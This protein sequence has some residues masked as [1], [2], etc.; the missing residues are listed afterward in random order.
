[1]Q[2]WPWSIATAW[3][4][5]RNDEFVEGCIRSDDGELYTPGLGAIETE[6]YDWRW[7]TPIM[8]KSLGC[9]PLMLFP[10][11]TA[12]AERVRVAINQHRLDFPRDEVLARFPKLAVGDQPTPSQWASVWR[13]N[14]PHDHRRVSLSHAAWWVASEQGTR[15]FDLDDRA[16]WKPAFATLLA[17]IV[18]REFPIYSTDPPPARPLPADLFDDIPVNY[19]S[20]ALDQFAGFPYRPGLH[21]FIDCD[22][23]EGGDRYFTRGQVDPTQ[24]GLQIGSAAL[25]RLLGAYSEPRPFTAKTLQEFVSK[26]LSNTEKP[27]LDDLRELTKGRGDRELIDDEYRRQ[28][29][30]KTGRPIK[31][32]R[33]SQQKPSDNSADK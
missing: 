2:I 31:P 17:P 32:G 21:S 4:L 27:T 20:R 30:E 25:L 11:V 15:I 6:A 10:T 7:N 23:L 18:D 12:A 28:L 24:R 19:P 9:R 14:S 8:G 33:R 5:T 29:Q 1:M 16:S 3:A 13:G 22:L 26:Y